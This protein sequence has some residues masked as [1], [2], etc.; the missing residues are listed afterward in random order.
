MNELAGPRSLRGIAEHLFPVIGVIAD[1]EPT[2]GIAA[3]SAAKIF[4]PDDVAE[5]VFMHCDPATASD[6]GVYDGEIES[7]PGRRL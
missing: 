3:R 4:D 1:D 6:L 7:A 5:W 2:K